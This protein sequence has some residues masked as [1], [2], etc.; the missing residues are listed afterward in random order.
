MIFSIGSQFSREFS[1]EESSITLRLTE[2]LNFHFEN[3]KYGYRVEKI[4]IGVICVSKDFEAFCVVRP[5]KV[6]KKEPA[7]EYELKLDFETFKSSSEE[8]RKQLLVSE[9]FKTTKEILTEKT[10]KGFEKEK[11]IDDLEAY[12]KQQGYLEETLT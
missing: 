4:Y 1:F 10:I 12:F 8:K 11:F 2:E 6:L 7:L 3:K 9:I 5:P